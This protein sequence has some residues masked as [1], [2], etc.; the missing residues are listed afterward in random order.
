MLRR[1]LASGEIDRREF[2]LLATTLGIAAP[3]ARRL[4]GAGAATAQTT[5]AAMKGGTLRIQM[6][7][8]PQTDPRLWDFT[9]PANT[10]G[11]TLERLVT[12]E[13]D[14][15]LA[16]TLLSGWTVN[17]YATE[18]LLTLR[19][20]VLWSDG[21]RLTTEDVAANFEA[22]ADRTLPGNSMA[23]RLASLID[24]AT[25]KLRNGAV[26][27]L[28]DRTLRVRPATG[29]ITLLPSLSDYPAVIQRRD[30][31][32]R[33]PLDHGIGT[34]PYRIA[35]YQPGVT[36]RLERRSDMAYWGTTHLD[37]IAFVDLGPDPAAALEAAR[38]GQIDM[39]HDTTG[40][41][42]PLFDALGWPRS[43]IATAATVV[44][45]TNQRAEIDGSRPY[46]DRRVRLA[47]ARAVDNAVLLEIGQGGYGRIAENHHVAPL[48]PEYVPMPPPPPA[49]DEA[50][51]LIAEAG[52][53][54]MVHNLVSVDDEWQ[55]ATADACA[56][57]M[58]DAGLRVT[59]RIVPQEAFRENWTRYAFSTTNWNH[60]D[61]GVQV[62]ALAYRSGEAWNETGFSN[63]EF[64]GLL[65]QALGLPAVAE[66][67]KLMGRMERILLDEGV[68]I[69]PYWRT[70]A[71]HAR[72][73]VGNAI[74]HPKDL[75]PLTRL[76]IADGG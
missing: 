75:I 51:R 63:T 4:A 61:L 11:G 17:A 67:R 22:W 65:T 47:F 2:L 12:T 44:I 3:L 50:R 59:R 60:R 45:R 57:Q 25:G 46:A 34:G 26:E 19:D 21:T 58:T 10:A 71:S 38:A 35:D 49:P 20:G 39:T 69:Q 29:D 5:A 68:V 14:G 53:A 27:I 66:R 30:L 55:R 37:A 31:I 43:E 74:R 76:W 9:E 48:H 72:P 6:R 33:S 15:T 13:R 56:A 28:D 36:A 16:G 42:M 54:D 40:R 8:P 1:A 18:Y 7:V 64:D 52:A 70:L 62:Y 41:F 24:P 23:S 32:G 73:G